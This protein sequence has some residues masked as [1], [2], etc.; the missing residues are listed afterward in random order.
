MTDIEAPGGDIRGASIL[1]RYSF[2][3]PLSIA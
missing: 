3:S 1:S 2:M